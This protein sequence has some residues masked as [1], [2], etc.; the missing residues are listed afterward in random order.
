V[1]NL[2]RVSSLDFAFYYSPTPPALRVAALAGQRPRRLMLCRVLCSAHAALRQLDFSQLVPNGR[3]ANTATPYTLSTCA[4]AVG[5]VRLLHTAFYRRSIN[6]APKLLGTMSTSTLFYGWLVEPK[7]FMHAVETHSRVKDPLR[8]L[9]LIRLRKSKGTLQTSGGVGIGSLPLEVIE[10]IEDF[11]FEITRKS[12]E[13]NRDWCAGCAKGQYEEHGD[14]GGGDRCMYSQN[15]VMTGNV[16][17]PPFPK[18]S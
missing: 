8:G 5:Y 14:G 1:I 17:V 18:E 3:Q 15:D 12:C 16:S 13:S 4:T 9:H 10:L 7:S 11:V 6:S 2:W